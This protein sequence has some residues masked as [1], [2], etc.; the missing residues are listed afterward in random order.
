MSK[1]K[2][3]LVS[4]IAIIVV[5]GGCSSEGT[6]NEQS[7]ATNEQTESTESTTSGEENQEEAVM[8][9]ITKGK[10]EETVKEKEI[11]I[12]DGAILYDVMK[13]N[14]EL[15]DDAGYITSIEGI[16]AK[17]SEQMAWMV[18]VNDEMASVG[19]K[20]LELSPGDSVNFD[21]QSWE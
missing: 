6:T 20:E 14:F 4:L 9:S 13:E 11:K 18:F 7:N 16:E 17:E 10:G 15:K 2:F 19:A 5:L 21:L 3:F 8:I 12:E 1:F